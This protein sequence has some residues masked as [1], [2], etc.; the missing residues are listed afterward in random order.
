MVLM[1]IQGL[2]VE[3]NSRSEEIKGRLRCDFEYFIVNEY[4]YGDLLKISAEYT[5]QFP[6]NLIPKNLKPL[7]Q[8]HNSITYEENG[9]RYNDYYG[10]VFSIFEAKK[11]QARIYGRDLDKLYEVIYLFILSRTGKFGDLHGTHRIHA[12]GIV[13][14]FAGLVCMQPMR[15]GKSTLFTELMLHH[16]VEVLSDDTPLINTKGELLP[17]PLRVSLDKIPPEIQTNETNCYLMKREFFK[18]KF[19]I[20]L[21]AFKRPVAQRTRYFHFVEAHRSTYDFPYVKKMSPLKLFRSLFKHMVI[22]VGLPIIFEYFWETG[23]SDFFKKTIIFLRRLTLA[24]RMA[25][26]H[27]GYDVYLTSDSKK[28][29]EALLKLL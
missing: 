24:M 5:D 1:N 20:S 13:K 23:S 25:L 4:T 14:D 17:F 10:N 6:Q 2:F 29:A 8:R 11:N 21:K 26:S 27:K 22:G 19:S 28:N 16:E 7:F 15:G 9:V 3:I 12:F 18:E